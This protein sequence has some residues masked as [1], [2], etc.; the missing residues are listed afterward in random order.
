MRYI[1]MIDKRRENLRLSIKRKDQSQD[2]TGII[3][4][5]MVFQDVLRRIEKV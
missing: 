1:F 4:D 2:L 5:Y 3:M